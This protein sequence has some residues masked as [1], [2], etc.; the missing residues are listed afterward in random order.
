MPKNISS[1]YELIVGCLEEK[2]EAWNHFI[3][4]YARLVWWSIHQTLGGS[5]F[6]GRTGLA[7]EIFQDFFEKLMDKARLTKV[8]DSKEISKYL[9]AAATYATLN[10]IR[11]LTREDRKNVWIDTPNAEDSSVEI[12]KLLDTEAK[13][14][15]TLAQ[16][17]EKDTIINEVLESLT[18]KERACMELHYMEDKTHKQIGLLLGMP[19]D[20][21][22]TILRRSREKIRARLLER[23]ITSDDL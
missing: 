14:F 16:E 20:T 1:D 8:R 3:E 9:S 7:E 23:N 18:F 15:V 2:K 12:L 13:N 22:S 21:V 6:K 17:K 11:S 5:S 10:K 4:R 19:Q